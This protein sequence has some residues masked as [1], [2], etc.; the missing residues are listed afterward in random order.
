[1]GKFREFYILDNIEDRYYDFHCTE[2]EAHCNSK[3]IDE[4]IT[5]IEKAA[6]TEAVELIDELEEFLTLRWLGDWPG[7]SGAETYNDFA[8]EALAKI[9][10]FKEKGE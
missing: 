7:V 10:E 4:V 8:N 6:F 1:M 5:V 3:E 2:M 9:E